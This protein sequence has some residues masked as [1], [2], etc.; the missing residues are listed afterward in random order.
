LTP[1]AEVLRK[2]WRGGKKFIENA[3]L[4]MWM[5]NY[6]ISEGAKDMT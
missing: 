1:V 6:I 3:L 5:G 4:Y 2:D